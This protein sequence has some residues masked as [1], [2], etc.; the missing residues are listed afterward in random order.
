MTETAIMQDAI[1]IGLCANGVRR[2]FTATGLDFRKFVRHGLP[3]DELE[4]TGD[5]RALSVV[6]QARKRQHVG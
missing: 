5:A 1:D 3:V 2:W 6:A 4:A